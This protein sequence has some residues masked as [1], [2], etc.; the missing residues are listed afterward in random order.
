[1]L[2]WNEQGEAPLVPVFCNTFGML[3][4]M[5]IFSRLK[6]NVPTTYSELLSV[7]E[8]LK[9]AG[10]A[11]P[12][13]GFNSESHLSYCFAYPH[14]MAYLREH[15]ETVDRLNAMEQD[16]ADFMRPTLEMVQD[17][18]SRGYVDLE[19]CGALENNYNA[20]LL[21]FLEGDVP[22][23][24]VSA[25]TS[26]GSKKREAQSEAFT[27][28]PFDYRFFVIPTT[29]EGG[30]FL[31]VAQLQFSVNASCQNL[32]MTN[33]FMR[34]LISTEELSEIAQA[35]RLV[36]V[37]ED[38][39]FDSVYA[40]LGQIP[41]ERTVY[42]RAMGLLDDTNI[43]LRRMAYQVVSG[44]MTVDEALAAFGSL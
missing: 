5:D 28:N 35:K 25:D 2:Y 3:V 4:N 36:T 37:T 1:M 19:A 20:V 10:Y 33:E 15:P 6:L 39:S 11:S 7:C 31:K 17:F 18:M 44:L 23:M 9:Q 43:Q 29:E 27:A 8:A 26:S 38:M 30:Y 40:S 14:Y 24:A 16:A 41:E 12:I 34:F 21:R 22:M 13:M 42:E 32:D